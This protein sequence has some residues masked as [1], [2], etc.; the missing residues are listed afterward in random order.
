M[1]EDPDLR[2]AAVAA[3]HQRV[4]ENGVGARHRSV[5]QGIRVD[6]RG[7]SSVRRTIGREVV[8]EP[9]KGREREV[10]SRGGSVDAEP[11]VVEPGGGVGHAAARG[12]EGRRAAVIDGSHRYLNL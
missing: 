7:R 11:D 3:S 9:V 2:V 1:E 5:L 4:T 6:P 12:S 10:R 8:L